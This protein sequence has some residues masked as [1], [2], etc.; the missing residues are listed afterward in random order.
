MDGIRFSDYAEKCCESFEA[1]ALPS[2]RELCY[3][4]RL[5][6]I[7]E[8]FEHA[9]APFTNVHRTHGFLFNFNYNTYNRPQH[10][11]VLEFVNQWTTVLDDYWNKVPDNN[12]TGESV[13]RFL[14]DDRSLN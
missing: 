7:I 4:L 14:N 5:Q 3:L 9:R 2:D 10:G 12:K 11:S 13:L 1:S 8:Q 6:Q